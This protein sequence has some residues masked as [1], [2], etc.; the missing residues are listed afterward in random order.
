MSSPHVAETLDSGI[1]WV[2]GDAFSYRPAEPIDLVIS[3]LFTHHLPDAEIV[4]FLQWMERVAT[5][6]W[7]INALHRERVPYYLFGALATLLSG[8]P[9]HPGK[10]ND[11]VAFKMYFRLA[12]AQ[13]TA[14]ARYVE[15][16][17]F[18]GGYA[19]LQ[20]VED[21]ADRLSS[22]F[23]V[24]SNCQ[25]HSCALSCADRSNGG[26]RIGVNA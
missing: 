17:L 3:S 6:G 10:Q 14:M 20:L 15:L 23:S 19:G 4:P 18:P 16:I 12:P 7:F 5:R 2:T 24:A 26:K 8:Y 22:A 25:G 11:L 9:R 13:Q 21:G 1:E